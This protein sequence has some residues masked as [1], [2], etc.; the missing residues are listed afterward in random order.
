[1]KA[2]WIN[3]EAMQVVSV[4]YS[5][6]ADLKRMVGGYIECAKHWPNGDVLY[7]DEEG[8]LKNYAYGFE[9]EGGHQPFFG[10]GV[11]VG[12][13]LGHDTA[14]TAD[15]TVTLGE[16]AQQIEFLHFR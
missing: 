1:M 4:P 15:P 6:L 5:G 9:I 11:L 2:Y 10:N 16:L 8:M 3:S 14:D 12:R 13:E 7:V